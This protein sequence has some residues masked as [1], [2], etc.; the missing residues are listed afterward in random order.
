MKEPMS[1]YDIFISAQINTPG[2]LASQVQG[3]GYY[4]R[5]GE[6]NCMPRRADWQHRLPPA[7]GLIDYLVQ[8]TN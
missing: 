3:P 2:T 6:R 4:R 5:K 8:N 7:T 1:I